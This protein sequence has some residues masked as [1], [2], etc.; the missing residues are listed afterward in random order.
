MKI[1]KA[2]KYIR[3]KVG[4]LFIIAGFVLIGAEIYLG[5]QDGVWNRFPIS[6]LLIDTIHFMGRVMGDVLPEFQMTSVTWQSFETSDFP[7][8]VQLFLGA[9]PMA[10]F[11]LISGYCFLRWSGFLGRAKSKWGYSQIL[12][13][14]TTN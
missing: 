2:L 10:S 8:P 5:W 9:I 4:K 6:M 3:M 14:L 11:F 13:R 7:H 12:N 1:K